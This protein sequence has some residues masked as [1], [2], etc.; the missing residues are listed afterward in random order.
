MTQNVEMPLAN[1]LCKIDTRLERLESK[2]EVGNY[3]ST[4]GELNRI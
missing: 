3:N 4:V 2:I 1:V